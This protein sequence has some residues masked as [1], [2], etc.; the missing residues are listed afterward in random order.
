MRVR[1]RFAPLL[2][3][4]SL[5]LAAGCSGAP[6]LPK[7]VVVYASLDE[8]FAK[9]IFAAFERQ[10]GVKVSAVYDTEST[11]TVGLVNRLI[12]EK[13]Q[14]RCDLYWN[15]EM[16]HTLRL[17]RM[18]LLRE[19]PLEYAQ[20]YPREYRSEDHDWHGFAARA[21][22]IIVNTDQLKRARWPK[23]IEDFVDPQWYDRCGVAKPLFGTTATHAAC[24]FDTWGEEEFQKFF[25][26]VKN[27]CRIL[28]GNRRVAKDVA[29]GKLL[30]GL[31]DTDDAMLEK[32]S[33]APVELIYP[34]QGDDG[35]GVLFIPNSLGLIAGSPH[36][37]TGRA[38]AEFLLTPMVE[39]RLV[40]G[41]SAQIPLNQKSNSKCRVKTP[42]EVR[43]MEVDWNAAAE[44]WEAASKFLAEEFSIAL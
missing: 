38:L 20:D 24:L 36:Q 15:N 1:R 16:L 43:S 33:G 25:K 11:K 14:P 27:N 39:C 5:V 3:P 42:D 26:R 10:T 23:S 35:L 30:F 41:P 29:A 9:P 12:A 21:R 44:G 34:D 8:E 28:A 22:V 31:T 32:E 6:E 18:G 37:E 40:D 17:K 7:E 2:L 19:Q 4:L 13:A